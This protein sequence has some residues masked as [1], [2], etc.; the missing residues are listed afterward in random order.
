MH[1]TWSDGSLPLEDMVEAARS[2][3]RPFVA[4]TDHSQALTIGHGMTPDQ[5]AEQGRAI[6]AM[7]RGFERDGDLVPRAPLDGGR[8]LP[9]RLARH[10]R[11]FARQ[12]RP[13]ARRVPLGVAVEGG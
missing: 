7:N 3:A 12:P 6:D 10:G 5:L 4:V 2:L 11:R 9:R 13:G 1:T 8:R